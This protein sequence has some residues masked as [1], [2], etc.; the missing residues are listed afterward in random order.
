VGETGTAVLVYT[1]PIVRWLSSKT[2]RDAASPT[3]RRHLAVNLRQFKV[4][5]IAQ[6]AWG[7]RRE[8][9]GGEK[10]PAFEV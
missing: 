7:E 3:R 6:W 4:L 8:R 2:L 5:R 9:V 10:I 1:N